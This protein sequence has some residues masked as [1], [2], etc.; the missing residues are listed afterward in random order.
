MKSVF[1][2]ARG[3]AADITPSEVPADYWNDVQQYRFRNGRAETVFGQ[4]ELDDLPLGDD[5]LHLIYTRR[6]AD[7]TEPQ[8]WPDDYILAF[9]KTEIRVTTEFD[10]AWEGLTPLSWP[11]VPQSPGPVTDTPQNYFTSAVLNGMPFIHSAAN[12]NRLPYYWTRDTATDFV[13]YSTVTNFPANSY[14]LGGIAA[15]K[16]HL[17]AWNIGGWSGA[18][19]HTILWSD[20]AVPG[21]VPTFLPDTTNEAGSV[22]LA[23]TPGDIIDCLYVN[24]L[25]WI[26]K[27]NALYSAQYVGGQS[28]FSFRLRHRAVGVVGR[29]CMESV[30]GAL[31]LV[32]NGDV[33]LCNGDQFTSVAD[34][35]VKDLL[36]TECSDVEGIFTVHNERLKEIWIYYPGP[37]A[38]NNKADQ[39]LIYN[40]ESDAWG[41]GASFPANHAIIAQYPWP[42]PDGVQPQLRFENHLTICKYDDGDGV[43]DVGRLVLTD[44]SNDYTLPQVVSPT[45]WAKKLRFAL[46]DD[47]QSFQVINRI[48][49]E[50]HRS[51]EGITPGS[52]KLHLTV[53]S[54]DTRESEFPLQERT[55]TFDPDFER[56]DR[57]VDPV[58]GR[59][60]DLEILTVERN[61]DIDKFWL[62]HEQD[63]YY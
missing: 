59:Y 38:V 18:N 35:R 8:F 47:P 6:D 14:V 5:Y 60:F 15:A 61:A 12:G 1:K 27:A 44:A 45:P 48:G 17:F 54:Y 19:E 29:N 16:Y 36:F 31:F 4:V 62:E 7:L 9:S 43:G 28:I 57:A 13:S 2:P 23:D 3:I 30:N 42:I 22:D 37:D 25:M 39:V 58:R 56:S 63:G 32:T 20:A 55:Y 50:T 52:Y 10:G 33:G 24:D 11:N 51:W 26:A 21:S 46:S 34:K 49:V 40:Y 53:R 41:R